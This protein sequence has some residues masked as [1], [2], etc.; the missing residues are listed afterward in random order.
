[1]DMTHLV[2]SRA[3]CPRRA[4]GAVIVKQKHVLTT[5]YNGA[6]KNFPHPIDVGC[7]RDEL[8]IPSGMMADVCP[9]LHAEQ[10]ALLQAA[11]FGVSVEGADIYC[12]TQPCTQCSRMIA[13]SGIKRVVFEEEYADPLAIGLLTTAGVE[14]WQWDHEAGAARR[15]E[16]INTW[17]QAQQELRVRWAQQRAVLEGRGKDSTPAE[18]A[19]PP[20]PLLPADP[21]PD[22]TEPGGGP[23]RVRDIS[24]DP[25]REEIL[26]RMARERAERLAKLG[27][28]KE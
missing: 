1:M 15:Y 13:N 3:T 7:I 9:C 14:L 12:T 5:G 6:P 18:E 2:K 4:V 10:N 16:K 27:T 21:A 26:K 11:L 20:Q 22:A 19:E 28:S 24:Q 17:E 23:T 25:R 8:E